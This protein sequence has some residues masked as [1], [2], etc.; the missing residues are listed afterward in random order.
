M[1]P[2]RVER[3]V[4]IHRVMEERIHQF[5]VKY[6][7]AYKRPQYFKKCVVIR[8]KTSPKK[9]VLYGINYPQIE[10]YTKF[11]HGLCDKYG[12]WDMEDILQGIDFM[13][14]KAGIYVFHQW[15]YKMWAIP[16][17]NKEVQEYVLNNLPKW[18]KVTRKK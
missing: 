11:S 4:E 13:L 7:F 14:I 8:W 5:A 3:L 15:N 10:E 9:N 2:T 17:E 18:A 12:L 16:D 6:G 1:N